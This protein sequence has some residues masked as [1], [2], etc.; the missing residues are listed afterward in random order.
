MLANGLGEIL[1]AE[2]ANSN[3]FA[4][5]F[6]GSGAVS[7]YIAENT[8]CRVLACDLQLFAVALA[9]GVISRSGALDAEAVWGKWSH[10]AH[11]RNRQSRL[12]QNAVM[13]DG[14]TWETAR[15]RN[16][17]RAREIC[18]PSRRP[19]TK[20]YGG[21]YFSPRQ[22]LALDS[23]RSTLPTKT[24]ERNVALAALICAASE[25]AAAPGHTAQP[26]QPTKKGA[27]FLFEAWRR[28]VHSHVRAALGRICPKFA[29]LTGSAL[30][31]EAEAVVDQLSPGDVA[32][33]DPPYS[34]VHYS[35]FYHVLETLARGFVSEIEGTGRYPCI[36]ARPSSQFSIKSTAGDALDRL[37]AKLASKGVRSIVTF[38]QEE[39]SNG[40]SG[41][42]VEKIATK[43]FRVSKTIVN[44]RFSTLGGNCQN[45]SARVP[46]YEII[47][48]MKPR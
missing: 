43:Y 45:R 14:K 47:L 28:D 2:A 40:L 8:N 12:Y 37:L 24:A 7:W 38:P 19:I 22:A 9:Q 20:A 33:L 48:N 35:R 29:K 16:V 44:G 1:K 4:D 10:E 18:A 21:H 13:F 32:F 42:A 34:G 27:E 30:V 23:L 46:A 17:S 11:E 25:C 36:E 39:T 26:F 41:L 5:L 3:R 6:A 15:R 31:S